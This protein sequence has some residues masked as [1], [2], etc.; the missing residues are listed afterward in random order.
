MPSGGELRHLD[1]ARGSTSCS[2]TL[3]ASTVG[4]IVF[5]RI[6]DILGRKKIYGSLAPGGPWGL[7]DSRA[8]GDGAGGIGDPVG[9]GTDVESSRNAG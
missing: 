3:L 1:G 7:R 4:A 5:G 9:P 8:R 6:A 2:A